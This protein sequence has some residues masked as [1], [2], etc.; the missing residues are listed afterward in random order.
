MSTT[1][2]LTLAAL[3]L[4]GTC[5]S[6]GEQDGM[7][8]VRDAQTGAL[9]NATPAEVK[10]L[11]AQESRRNLMTRQP[12]PSPVVIRK[13]G[14]LHKHLG[15]RSMVY[16]VVTRDDAGK[17]GMECVKGADAA[18]AALNKEEHRHEER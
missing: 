5:A 2:K 11:K 3:A 12:E 16:S 15:E 17:L 4:V 6:A 10:V 18:D 1:I 13:D 14:T 9:R 8:V 7:V